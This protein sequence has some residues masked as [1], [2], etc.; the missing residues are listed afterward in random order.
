MDLIKSKLNFFIQFQLKLLMLFT[1]LFVYKYIYMNRINQEAFLRLFVIILLFLW[2][3]RL[4][5][6]DELSWEKTKLTIPILLFILVMSLSLTRKGVIFIGLKDYINFLAYF[7]IF[8]LVI[9]F[10]STQKEF[11]SFI[12]LFFLISFLVSLYTLLQY[13]GIDLLYKKYHGLTSTLGQ[14]N[15]ISNYIAMVFP[16]IFSFF[17]LQKQK[18]VRTIY[19]ILLSILYINIMI[20]QSRGIWIS[21]FVSVIVGFYFIYKFKLFKSFRENRKWLIFLILTFLVITVIYSTDNPLNKS[22]ETVIHR[23][24]TTFDKND[25]SINTRLL[26][27]NNTLNMI[28]DHPWLGSGIGTFKL[29]YQSYQADYLQENPGY[30]K[31]WIKAGEAHN[32]YLQIWAELGIIGLGM[33]ILIIYFYYQS[34]LKFFKKEKN[35]Q[36]QLIVLGMLIGAT[37]FLIHCLFCF[38]LHVPALGAAFFMLIG[39]NIRFTLGFDLDAEKQSGKI[40]K[41]INF[42]N[43]KIVK[44]IIIVLLLVITVFLI[45]NMVIRPYFAELYYFRGMLLNLNYDFENSLPVLKKAVDLDAHN[46]RIVHALGATYYNLN[47]YD[48]AIDCFNRAKKYEIDKYTF[49][50]SGLSYFSKGMYYEAEKEFKY[51]IYLEPK[52]TESYIDLAYLYA[53]QKDYDKAIIEWNKV[54]GIETDFSERYNVLY[55]IGLTYNKKEMP[56]QALEYFVQALQL[57]PEGDPIEKEIEEEINKIYK[58]KLEK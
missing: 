57:V 41:K 5:M 45:N 9:N 23:A 25:L 43:S 26:I 42:K 17:L 35:D 8:F 4:M 49:Y 32:E 46:G 13:Y 27:W 7:I 10:V 33:F 56:D 24:A 12:R 50:L 20:C 28:K 51:A 39:L 1:M 53:F 47:R 14:K 58:S 18:K 55:F 36:K 16:V 34:V 48:E 2:F 40:L 37:C 54:L 21:I 19:Y 52:F 29:N 22:T 6:V 15:W 3:L 38:P 31:Y 44:A 30:I 11:N